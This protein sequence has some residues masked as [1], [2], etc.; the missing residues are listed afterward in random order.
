MAGILVWVETF[1]GELRKASRE[2]LG[3]GQKF[4]DHQKVSLDAV[5]FNAGPAA[6]AE[7]GSMGLRKLFTVSGES[8]AKYSSEGY[9][10]AVAEAGLKSGADVYL[11]CAS[12]LGRDLTGRLAAKLDAAL[13]TDVTE[14]L[15]DKTPLSVRRPVYS[16]KLL[17]QTELL[18]SCKVL[19][20]RPNVF[21]PA[22]TRTGAV[23]T[24]ALTLADVKIRAQVQKAVAA[25]QGVLDVT[26][27]EIIVSGGRGVG[28]PDGFKVIEGLAHTLNAAVGASRAAVDA[29]WIPYA[30]QVGQTGKVVSPVLYIAC[31][32]SG[33]IQHFAGMGSS[34]FIV[35]VNIDK[36]AP[37][38]AKADFAIVGDLFKVV[39]V[40][41]QELAKARAK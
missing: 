17:A 27:A 1:N 14:I 40:L 18:A 38:M 32:I 16:G 29:G 35:A 13:A 2:A 41:Q 37:I 31:G 3:A 34:K 6:L 26:E 12:S 30:H 39:P 19:S 22:Q 7:L 25:A 8:F 10:A 23:E 9:C 36:E 33:A 28:G 15:W 21:A 11:A 5:V 4:A 20:L 24:V